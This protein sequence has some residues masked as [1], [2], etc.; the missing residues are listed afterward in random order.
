M[1]R[2][3]AVY[4][5]LLAAGVVEQL[6]EPD[7]EGRTA[8]LTVDLQ[9]D[10]ALNQPLSPFAL[11]AIDLLDPESETYALDVVSVIESTL[12]NPRPVLSAQRFKARGEAVAAMKA[13]GIE[14]EERME[15]LE[16]V[17]YPQPL[18]EL[19]DAAYE[20][21]RRGHPWVADHEL[22]PKSVARDLFERSMTFVEY[23]GFYQLARS[24][25]LV[26]RYLADA[27]KA[28]RQ[29][30]P[31]D[32]R[33]EE[34]G[35][36][37]VW[38][39]ELVRQVDSSLLDEWERA[40]Q[41]ERARAP[42]ERRACWTTGRRRSP[43]TSGRSGCWSATRCS[44][45]SSWSPAAGSPSSASSTARPAGTSRCGR[46]RSAPY[47]EQHGDAQ[48][49]RGRPR[50][51]AVDH[52]PDS[53]P[54]RGVVRQIFDDPAGDHDWGISAEVD[55]AAS[56]E[57]G[58][59]VVTVT[60]VDELELTPH[61]SKNAASSSRYSSIVPSPTAA[62]RTSTI[63][64]SS[65]GVRGSR[66]ARRRPSPTA[67]RRPAARPWP[68]AP[69]RPGTRRSL[70]IGVAGVHR[71]LHELEP[72]LLQRQVEVGVL[73]QHPG[74]ERAVAADQR[75]ARPAVLVEDLGHPRV[76]RAV[77]LV[78]GR[79]E[80]SGVR[81]SPGGATP[82]RTAWSSTSIASSSSRSAGSSTGAPVGGLSISIGGGADPSR[83]HA[84][85]RGSTP[86]AVGAVVVGTPDGSSPAQPATVSV[87]DRQDGR[88][89]PSS[90][91]RS[92]PR[93]RRFC[94]WR[95]RQALRRVSASKASGKRTNPRSDG[96]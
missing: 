11:A 21:Y 41:P 16:D 52:R 44:A 68:P 45:G 65:I 75:P 83:R 76:V 7:A 9:A 26:L 74:G 30:V 67:C 18:A 78:P 31:E 66:V 77:G 89:A 61:S 62:R 2:A 57:A 48:H 79:G 37:I 25:G 32:A 4:R 5:A 90:C 91:H 15:L 35:D 82:V 43:R 55:L 20:T 72:A 96:S 69:G 94:T 29:T 12:E 38:L 49:R 8:R 84:R 63:A 23:V 33:T 39:G 54:A 81:S 59:A 13:E 24:E 56:D 34:L 80:L 6:D 47:F 53:R 95:L 58:V 93:I 42:A 40:A 60:A 85:R 50:P 36:L 14:Y 92:E 22:K 27:Y 70:G 17:T 64:S 51:A 1:H 73:D 46:T 19:L 88:P 87:R 28:L 10:F 3:I 86:T 71:A